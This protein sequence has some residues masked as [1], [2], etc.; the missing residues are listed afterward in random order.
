MRL[1]R[2]FAPRNDRT[3]YRIQNLFLRRNYYLLSLKMTA[4]RYYLLLNLAMFYYLL[5]ITDY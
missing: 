4:T 2:R 5:L 1:L 3:V